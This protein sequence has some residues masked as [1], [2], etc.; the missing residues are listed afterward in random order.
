M[1]IFSY[2]DRLLKHWAGAF[3]RKNVIVT[4]SQ[5][6]FAKAYLVYFHYG[7]IRFGIRW[8][9]RYLPTYRAWFFM[10]W[11][12]TIAL[13]AALTYVIFAHAPHK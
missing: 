4:D 2:L 7:R 5:V 12:G 6:T 10:A 1:N 9:I 13:T 3:P 8:P 11:L